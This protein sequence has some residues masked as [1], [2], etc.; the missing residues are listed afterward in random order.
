MLRQFCENDSES[1]T[2]CFID[3]KKKTL[4]KKDFIV[5]LPLEITSC[6]FQD[7][8]DRNAISKTT[9]DNIKLACTKLKKFLSA[10]S[11]TKGKVVLKHYQ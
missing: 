5:T 10:L 8:T 6:C 1:L 3:S 2:E 4:N 7:K 11:M 9:N